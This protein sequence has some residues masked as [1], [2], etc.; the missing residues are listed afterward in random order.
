MPWRDKEL[1]V[2]STLEEVLRASLKMLKELRS[3]GLSIH[4]IAGPITADGDHN[5]KRNLA[6]LLKQRVELASKLGPK[7]FV[8][9]SPLIFSEGLYVR[10]GT[11][12][13]EP[14]QRE[15][16]FQEF[17]DKLLESGLIDEI[18]F[19]TGWERSVGAK[20]EHQTAITNGIKIDYLKKV[21]E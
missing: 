8:F 1:T 15:A 10:L 21:A 5:I 17:W 4:H 12:D 14:V 13:K 20:C 2:C 11:F 6:Q 7:A 19:T 18:H 16:E 3:E 9:T